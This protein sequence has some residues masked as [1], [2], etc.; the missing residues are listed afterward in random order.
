[1]NIPN[2]V[3]WHPEL[4]AK[5]D[6]LVTEILGA[7]GERNQFGH[8]ININEEESHLVAAALISK[9][10]ISYQAIDETLEDIKLTEEINNRQKCGLCG[11]Q[12]YG[13]TSRRETPNGGEMFGTFR[14]D[15]P[16]CSV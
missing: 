9:I 12:G 16:A 11:G 5:I 3:K 14:E 1:M 10:D 2:T 7:D 8:L 15:C 13:F 4:Q 6:Q